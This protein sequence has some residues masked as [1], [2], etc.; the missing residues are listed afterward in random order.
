MEIKVKYIGK[1]SWGR[2]L[3][4]NIKNKHVY[5]VVDD[6]YYTTSKD[7]EPDCPL[8]KDICIVIVE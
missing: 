2:K 3:Y 6:W 5:A 1:D 8:R 4:Q 7:G